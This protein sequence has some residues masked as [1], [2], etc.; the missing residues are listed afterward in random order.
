MKRDINWEKV[1]GITFLIIFVGSLI[2]FAV[3]M[4]LEMYFV[5]MGC[6]VL[7][8]ASWFIVALLAHIKNKKMQKE[9]G[10]PNYIKQTALVIS[11]SVASESDRIKDY[12]VSNKSLKYRLVINYNDEKVVLYSNKVYKKGDSVTIMVNAKAPINYPDSIIIWQ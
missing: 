1:K 4:S 9:K 11:C 6:F 10:K 3:F 2:G 5:G 12:L 8:I 7:G